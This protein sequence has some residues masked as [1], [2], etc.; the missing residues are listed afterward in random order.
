MDSFMLLVNYATFSDSFSIIELLKEIVIIT[1]SSFLLWY[2]G[3]VDTV[4]C[5]HSGFFFKI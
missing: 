2:G 4:A 3:L 1:G 5:K